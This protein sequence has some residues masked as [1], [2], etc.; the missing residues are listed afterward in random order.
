MAHTALIS[1]TATNRHTPY[2]AVTSEYGEMMRGNLL[3]GKPELS[4][5]DK[6]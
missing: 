2:A 5:T 1:S 6:G 3:D 4:T